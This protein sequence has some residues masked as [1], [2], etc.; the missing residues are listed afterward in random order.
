METNNYSYKH[1]FNYYTLEHS[2]GY[3][4]QGYMYV[5]AYMQLLEFAN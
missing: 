2:M 4:V 3:Y 5:H 1:D